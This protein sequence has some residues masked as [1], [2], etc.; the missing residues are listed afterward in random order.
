VLV[1]TPAGSVRGPKVCGHSRQDA[2][3]LRRR[4]APAAEIYRY[5]DLIGLR[6]RA[7]LAPMG[8][9]FARVGA[10]VSLRG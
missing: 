2:G 7:L 1:A 3:A 9:T 6:D 10:V 4:D 5:R 8:Y